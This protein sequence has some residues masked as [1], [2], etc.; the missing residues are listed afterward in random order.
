[1]VQLFFIIPPIFARMVNLHFRLRLV[2]IDCEAF[3]NWGGC[4]AYKSQNHPVQREVL[5][6]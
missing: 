1:M 3:Y 4:N 5:S 6:N 2:G